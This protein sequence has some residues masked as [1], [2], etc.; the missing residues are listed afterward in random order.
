MIKKVLKS[1][2]NTTKKDENKN[3]TFLPHNETN[4][5]QKALTHS[6]EPTTVP[7][8]AE[9]TSKLSKS[10]TNSKRKNSWIKSEPK[11]KGNNSKSKNLP[12]NKRKPTSK[13]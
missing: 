13:N 12:F 3:S 10:K 9:Q 2:S 5:S 1:N 4:L 11:S 8:E 6:K 7:Q